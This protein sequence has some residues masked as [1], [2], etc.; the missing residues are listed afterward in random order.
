VTCGDRAAG[1]TQVTKP[2]KD[3]LTAVGLPPM[4]STT[5]AAVTL[6]PRLPPLA[7]S[8]K[9]DR[10]SPSLWRRLTISGFSKTMVSTTIS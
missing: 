4:L 1:A 3:T 2:A 9:V 7:A 5:L 6:A 8:V 10:G